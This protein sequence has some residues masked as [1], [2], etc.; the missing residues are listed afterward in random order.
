MSTV[1]QLKD[2]LDQSVTNFKQKRVALDNCIK[3]KRNARSL[4]VKIQSLE[5]SLK[6]LNVA[7]TSWV[8]KGKFDAATLAAETYSSEWLSQTWDDVDELMDAANELIEGEEML[9]T[10]QPLSKA[11][12]LSLL[13]KQMETLQ[14][15]ITN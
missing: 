5:D 1:N 2:A 13:R 15:G 4:K 14:L 8:S 12:K 3:K 10:E 9:N 7:H 6:D 11:Q